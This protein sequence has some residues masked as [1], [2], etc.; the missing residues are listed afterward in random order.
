VVQLLLSSGAAVEAADSEGWRSLHWA[1]Q[2]GHDAVVQLLLQAGATAEVH[3]TN[4]ELLQQLQQQQQQQQR[5]HGAE[6]LVAHEQHTV[7]SNAQ[8]RHL[9]QATCEV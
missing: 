4:G 1:S 2:N 3:D 8:F 9:C 6:Y 5:L 7:P